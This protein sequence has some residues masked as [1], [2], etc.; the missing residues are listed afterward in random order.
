MTRL[1]ALD[2]VVVGSGPNGLA[3]AIVL[4]QAGCSVEVFERAER[5]G[6]G[7]HTA[8]LTLP[9]FHHDLCSAV[10]PLAC[11][12]PFFARL[13]LAD[14]GL[15]FVHSPAVLAHPFDDGS[16][17]LQTRA[18][19]ETAEQLGADGPAYRTLMEP[20][21]ERWPDLI[22][23]A[24]QPVL[25][26]PDHPLLM[27]RLGWK[28][29][30]SARSLARSVFSDTR[31][32]ALWAGHAAHSVVPLEAA[33][34]AAFGLMLALSAHAVGWPLIE[35]GSARLADALARYLVGL[36]GRVHTGMDIRSLN[37]LPP[38]RVVLADVTPRQLA[39]LA[40]DRLP[41][42]Y[43]RKIQG[44]RH[45]PGV[46]KIDW[47]LSRPIPWRAAAC[48]QSATVHLGGTLEEIAAS[49]AAAA[50]GKAAE[51]PFTL[52]AQ[53][54]LFD[55]SRAPHGRH[56]GW[57]YCHVP[58][59]SEI[60]CTARIEAQVERFAPGFRDT[61][62]ARRVHSPA[63]LERHNPNYV[64]GDIGG[65]ANDLRQVVARPFLQRCAYATPLPGVYLC[66]SSTPPGGGVHGMCGYHAARAALSALDRTRD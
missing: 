38:A 60:D 57:A 3:A 52:L 34:T 46:F 64:G 58:N 54:S 9:G 7:L 40:G 19:G 37:D 21:V 29:L 43:R 28:G 26:W 44:Y 23:D 20:F 17:V 5:V 24:L 8:Q 41:A 66:S 32:A 25:R 51:R 6:G 35:G 10:H 55:A 63:Q 14:Y 45:G 30:R 47:A 31:A 2:A 11:A 61:I 53:P 62:L 22:G 50:G 36:G 39:A 12:S 56:I 13:P 48:A 42:A 65:G 49:E 4:A 33:G 59:G 18:V 16:A 1:S 27:A 15:R